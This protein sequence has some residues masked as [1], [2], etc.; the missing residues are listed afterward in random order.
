[1]HDFIIKLFAGS[2]DYA[3]P[4]NGRLWYH[5]ML[6]ESSSTPKFFGTTFKRQCDH[7]LATRFGITQSNITHYNL[8]AIYLRLVKHMM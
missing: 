7:Y 1:M 4:V 8:K 2:V 6:H 5:L 3:K